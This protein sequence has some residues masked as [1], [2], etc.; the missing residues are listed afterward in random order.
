MTKYPLISGPAKVFQL[1]DLLRTLPN[2]RP[3]RLDI[4][5]LLQDQINIEALYPTNS[6]EPSLAEQTAHLGKAVADR[7]ETGGWRRP[8]LGF[9]R[10]ASGHEL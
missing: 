7:P 6:L 5:A 4:C 10:I 9:E 2:K 1:P 8:D 3:R